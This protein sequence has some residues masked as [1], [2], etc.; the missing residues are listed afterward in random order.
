MKLRSQLILLVG[1]TAAAFLASVALSYTIQAPLAAMRAES[2]SFQELARATAQLEVEASQ[3]LL[4]PITP[5]REVYRQS[6][7][8]FHAAQARMTEVKILSSAN[9][10]LADAVQ[11]TVNLGE[12]TSDSLSTLDGQLDELETLMSAQGISLDTQDWGSLMRLTST[13][14]IKETTTAVYSLIR[15]TQQLANLNEGL[16]VTRQVVEKKDGEIQKEL[17]NLQQGGTVAGSAV[18]LITVFL[19]LV[20]SVMVARSIARTVAVL[21]K[22]IGKVGSGD[23]TVRVQSKRKD[24]LGL[25]AHDINA[26]LDTLTGAL[27]RIQAGSAENVEVKDQLVQS[28]SSATSSAT[29]IEANSASILAQLRKADERIQASQADL[30]DV[31][32]LLTAFRTRLEAQSREVNDADRSVGELT[33]AIAKISQLSVENRDAVETLLAESD[34][35]REVFDRSFTKVAEIAD[36]VSAIQDLV[37]TIAE[38]ASQTNIL[39][40]NAAIE[41]AHAGEAG[42]GFAVV[43]DEIS[44]LAAA[45]AES[46]ARIADTIQVVVGKIQESAATRTETLQAFDAIESQIGRVSTRG[47]S[48]DAEA[49][50]MNQGAD[51]IRQVMES[52][53][54]G[55]EATT[56]EA[57]RIASV[58]A[59]FGDVLGQVGRISHE[60]VS[61]IGEISTGLTEISRTVG[62][63]R[64]Q[65]D[66]MGRVGTSLNEAVNAFRT[67]TKS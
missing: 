22:T 57:Q 26:F 14:E 30:G 10:T 24:E 7:E 51:R 42:K 58:M 62:E 54:D 60:V 37:G 1:G 2:A 32:N 11:A 20:L 45:S 35:G 39:A 33:Q 9:Q 27:K 28:V 47:R 50:Q 21:G 48:I 15:L 64:N 49:G 44:K 18:M 16:T 56:Q 6:V 13:G 43:S 17:D 59:S 8:R 55:A 23:L 66:R 4:K 5:Q 63:V 67:E 19:A 52:L 40:L 3:L 46:S 34:R 31:V 29:E 12:L 25:L 36:S 61:N 38:I 53:T 65:A 41:A